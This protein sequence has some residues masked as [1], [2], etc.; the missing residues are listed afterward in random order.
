MID[1]F[2]RTI[3]Y[4]RIS[5]TDRCNLR[6]QYCLP[7]D[8]TNYPRN[9]ILQ[10]EEFLRLCTI[11]AQLGVETFR[12]TGGEPLVRKGCVPFIGQLK[13]IPG[14]KKVTITTNGILLDNYIS[15]LVNAGLDGL[16]ISLDSVCKEN[17]KNITG[18]DALDNVLQA[19]QKAVAYG[20]P[21]KINTVIIKGVN[22][23][24]I[25]QIVALAEKLP[26]NVRFIELMPTMANAEMQGISN[27]EVLQ[28][29]T[30]QYE[31]LTPDASIYGAGPARY[32]CSNHLIGK[33]GFISPLNQHF[34]ANCNRL[35]ISSTGFL[36]LCL[37]HPHGVDLK[38]LLRSG[39]SDDEIKHAILTSTL[40][41]PQQ[42]FL[43]SETNVQDMS[44]IGG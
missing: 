35:R 26:I 31:D 7:G 22:D 2:S 5:I 16:N 28:T 37:H 4:L 13:T 25:L 20:I 12:V 11:M 32:Y 33:V 3:D 14:V 9:E 6:C 30:S 10:Y 8:F 38:Q 34:C 44:K 43:Q 27:A 29:I 39:A 17:Y 21:T 1:S 24:E 23:H 41:K 36:R 40:E 15:D 42:H 18:A 19:L